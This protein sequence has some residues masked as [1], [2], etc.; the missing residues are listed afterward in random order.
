MKFKN[1]FRRWP[2]SEVYVEER[3]ESDSGDSHK[4]SFK[5]DIERGNASEEAPPQKFTKTMYISVA[6]AAASYA[7]HGYNN[8]VTNGILV[9]NAFLNQFPKIDT[10]N[11]DDADIFSRSRMQGL[12][13]GVYQLGCALGAVLCCILSDRLGRK[14]I[15]HAIG[16]VN[17]IGVVLQ[18]SAYSLGHLIVG[19]IVTGVGMGA[20]HA[21]FP[22]YLAECVPSELRGMSVLSCA[23]AANFGHFLGAVIEVA[24]YFVKRSAQW[25][26]PLGLELLF[27]VASSILPFWCPESPRL[28]IRKHRFEDAC[29]SY[30]DLMCKPVESNEVRHELKRLETNM[31]ASGASD[32]EWPPR[33]KYRVLLAIFIQSMSSLSGIEIV[34]FFSTETFESQLHFSQLR[35]RYFT[36]GL[37]GTQWLFA[38]VAV[39]LVDTLG[40]RELVLGCAMIMACSMGSLCGLTWTGATAAMHKAAIAFYYILMCAFPMGFHLVPSLYVAELSP[41][42]FKHRI[43]ALTIALHFLC[44]FMITMVTPIAFEAIQSQYYFVFV[45]ANLLAF[46]VV[47]L[48]FPETKGYELEDIDEMFN[49]SGKF[50]VIG[51]RPLRPRHIAIEEDIRENESRK[52]L[53]SLR[54]LH[55]QGGIS[56]EG[57]PEL[58]RSR[59]MRA[60]KRVFPL[61]RRNSTLG[62]ASVESMPIIMR[63]SDMLPSPFRE[64]QSLHSKAGDS[65]SSDDSGD[66]EEYLDDGIGG[67]VM[68]MQSG[69]WITKTSGQLGSSN[70]Q[71]KRPRPA[72]TAAKDHNLKTNA[73]R[74]KSVGVHVLQ[75]ETNGRRLSPAKVWM[76][77]QQRQENGPMVT[78]ALDEQDVRRKAQREARRRRR[79][80][81]RKSRLSGQWGNVGSL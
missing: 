52:L 28:L 56:L 44:S 27:A 32:S 9:S 41:A 16:I 43:T 13:V 29:V 64:T 22:L 4:S 50:L 46:F 79:V 69:K 39:F 67:R 40:R 42:R 80:A 23:S 7:M 77:L 62:L 18:T 51:P 75:G 21:T 25:R 65:D 61:R 38:T 72:H 71:G 66:D 30:S 37:Q 81:R 17:I 19:R 74:R 31:E 48:F 20:A 14:P 53:Q 11:A 59:E 68:P 5:R 49:E 15:I 12:T 58:L 47:L 8:S 26:A 35:S 54:S 60:Q 1:L 55:E 6:A 78:F 73:T 24:F 3:R 36:M 10:I 33:L 34:S 45:A 76:E 57:M 2:H 63:S 70:A